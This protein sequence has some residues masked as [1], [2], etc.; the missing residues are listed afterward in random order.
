MEVYMVEVRFETERTYREYW[1][2]RQFAKEKAKSYN[3]AI[4]YDNGFYNL[5]PELQDKM[6][7]SPIVS[8]RVLQCTPIWES[9][10]EV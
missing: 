7:A 6:I 8:V 9:N 2:D 4:P 1:T 10:P 3:G 5:P